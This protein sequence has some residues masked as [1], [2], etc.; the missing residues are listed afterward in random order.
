MTSHNQIPGANRCAENS[1]EMCVK[2][3]VINADNDMCGAEECTA[4]EDND[5]F[6][7]HWCVCLCWRKAPCCTHCS[8]V[9]FLTDLLTVFLFRYLHRLTWSQRGRCMWSLICPDPPLRVRKHP[10]L[11]RRRRREVLSWNP[12]TQVHYRFG[13]LL[14]TVEKRAPLLIL[15]QIK[16]IKPFVLPLNKNSFKHVKMD[17]T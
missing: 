15:R 2:D 5:L 17:S 4:S 13:Q 12:L 11:W 7:V 8:A 14:W 9:L 10:A 3:G 16:K 6:H 1:N